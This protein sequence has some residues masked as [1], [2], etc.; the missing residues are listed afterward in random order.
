LQVKK[1]VIP[2]AGLGT[3]FL[4][5]TKAVPKELIPVVNKPVIQYVIEEAAA[6]GIGEAIFVVSSGK[7]AILDHF[8]TLFEIEE[9][10][11]RRG[12][13]DQLKELEKLHDLVSVVSVRQKQALGLGHAIY[14]STIGRAP[15][16]WAS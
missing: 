11:R 3:R 5:A 9:T 10:L 7:G 6:S 4:P 1:A 13:H 8:D 16:W 15:P 2:A 14:T 12:K